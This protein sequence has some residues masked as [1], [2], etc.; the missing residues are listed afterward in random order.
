MHLV[1]VLAQFSLFVALA[2]AFRVATD[3]IRLTNEAHYEGAITHANSDT[4]CKNVHAAFN[5]ADTKIAVLGRPVALYA[6]AD[7]TQAILTTPPS[8][9]FPNTYEFA[10]MSFK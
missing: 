8:K 7:C 4:E 2:S 5:S 6:G 3:Y 9:I 1:A 10:I